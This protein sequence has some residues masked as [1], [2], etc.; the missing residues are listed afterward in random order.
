MKSQFPALLRIQSNGEAHEPYAS[1]AVYYGKG[2]NDKHSLDSRR[3]S[4]SNA[5]T[6]GHGKPFL[7]EGEVWEQPKRRTSHDALSTIDR[8]F[9]IEVDATLKNLLEREDT[10]D[11]MQITIDD[12][13]PKVKC[14][15]RIP[16]FHVDS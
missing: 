14:S 5:Y 1:P 4:S 15:L 2:A 6:T 9:I 8:K 16:L 11:N 12:C 3:F 7:L 10:D 13:G